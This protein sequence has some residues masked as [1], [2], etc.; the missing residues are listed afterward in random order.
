MSA[1]SLVLVSEFSFGNLPVAA[2]PPMSYDV[3]L[4]TP[5]V[6]LIAPPF[7]NL[8]AFIYE[9]NGVGPAYGWSPT[10]GTWNQI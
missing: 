10:S 6:Q 3:T 9:L 2:N 1:L 7:T 8:S 4:G 5:A